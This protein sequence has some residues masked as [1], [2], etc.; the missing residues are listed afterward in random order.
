MSIITVLA[1]TFITLLLV[2]VLAACSS[3]P[4]RSSADT[5][6]SDNDWVGPA[7]LSQTDP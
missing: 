4:S 6:P 7:R 3:F 2:V 5:D 1:L